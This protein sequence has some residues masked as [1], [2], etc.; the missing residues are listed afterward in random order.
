ME[1]ENVSTKIRDKQPK[2]LDY[3]EHGSLVSTITA[4][5]T[6]SKRSENALK[7][8]VL[9]RRYYLLYLRAFEF[10]CMFEGLL[11]K[12]N[13]QL[14]NREFLKSKTDT[15]DEEPIAKIPKFNTKFYSHKNEKFED[16]G[17]RKEMECVALKGIDQSNFIPVDESSLIIKSQSPPV[18]EKSSTIIKR[19]KDFS[20]FNR[21]NRK[22]KN[23]AIF[24]YRHIDTDTDQIQVNGSNDSELTASSSSEEE[25]WEY[26][27]PTL[28]DKIGKKIISSE[29]ENLADTKNN[30]NEKS[31]ECPQQ[32]PHQITKNASNKIKVYNFYFIL[33]VNF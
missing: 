13:F 33:K 6:E 16:S 30:V 28:E 14:L 2:S 12:R 22:S 7:P 11:E 9:E 10:Q 23:C 18:K 19:P 3:S 32:L 5:S 17:G 26:T 8:N 21:S 1:K 29:N 25:I 20:K 24:Y 15:S 27:N 4:I 31:K